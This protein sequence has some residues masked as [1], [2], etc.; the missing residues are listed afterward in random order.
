MLGNMTN[1]AIP[2]MTRPWKVVAAAMAAFGFVNGYV[3]TA[4]APYCGSMGQCL[5][6]VA[7]RGLAGFAP[8]SLIPG[9]IGAVVFAAVVYVVFL[10][11]YGVRKALH[12]QLPAHDGQSQSTPPTAAIQNGP[13][14]WPRPTPLLVAV[15]VALAWAV[16]SVGPA[17]LADDFGQLVPRDTVSA[18]TAVCDGY[19]NYRLIDSRCVYE[20][21]V[22]DWFA[23]V[24]PHPDVA[25]TFACLYPNVGIP[26]LGTS[27]ALEADGMCHERS[28]GTVDPLIHDTVRG[29]QSGLFAFLAVGAAL[30]LWPRLR[31]ASL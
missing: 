21:P 7:D 24:Q 20:R 9:A 23:P 12:R 19:A 8:A 17:S 22:E 15:G 26:S 4:G 30:L 3:G 13:R 10:L 16:L 2:R 29:G 27:G 28:G 1:V 5:K 31:A 18:S 25:P 6:V 11:P 14:Q